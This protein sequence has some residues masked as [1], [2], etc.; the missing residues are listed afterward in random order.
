MTAESDAAGL[1]TITLF[2]EMQGTLTITGIPLTRQI[3]VP[4][5]ATADLYDLVGNLPDPLTPVEIPFTFPPR[6]S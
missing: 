5:A 6:R 4:D 2:R 3:T 1:L